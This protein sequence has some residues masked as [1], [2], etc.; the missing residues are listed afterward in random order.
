MGNTQFQKGDTINGR[1]YY[2]DL[3][4]CLVIPFYN[5]WQ[6]F[7]FVSLLYIINKHIFEKRIVSYGT[8]IRVLVFNPSLFLFKFAI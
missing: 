2:M 5:L 8:L 4:K 6:K 7:L 1:Y 3:S